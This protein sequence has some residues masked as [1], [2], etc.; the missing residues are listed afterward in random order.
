MT[1][2]QRIIEHFGL[3]VAHYGFRPGETPGE[4]DLRRAVRHR[5]EHELFTATEKLVRWLESPHRLTLTAGDP[6][7]VALDENAHG[8]ITYGHARA[9]ARS[10]INDRG[11]TQ[12]EDVITV[13]ALAITGR[14]SHDNIAAL[15]RVTG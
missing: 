15:C 10:I 7:P 2:L 12:S 5:P 9:V 14:M 11:A 6:K 4:A 1:T 13:A 3:T 8:F